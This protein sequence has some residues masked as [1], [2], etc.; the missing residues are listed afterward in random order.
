MEAEVTKTVEAIKIN[1]DLTKQWEESLDSAKMD[2]LNKMQEAKT[3][4]ESF[5][6]ELPSV[7]KG[8]MDIND[9]LKYENE[10]QIKF[11]AAENYGRKKITEA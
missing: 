6:S 11:K 10:K 5:R 9:K 2:A 8:K 3:E 4:I 1:E 7:I